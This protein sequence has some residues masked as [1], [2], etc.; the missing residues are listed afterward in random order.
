MKPEIKLLSRDGTDNRLI[1]IDEQPM[2][3]KLQT[4]YCY[5]VGFKDGTKSEIAFIDPSGGPFITE[6]TE[7][8]GHK[9]KA[10]HNDGI[11]EFEE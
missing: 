11:I 6:G 10:I 5:R 9:V 2:M 8:E 7:I 3:Y 4:P 1:Q